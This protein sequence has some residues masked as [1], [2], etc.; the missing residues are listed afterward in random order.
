M[1][2]QTAEAVKLSVAVIKGEIAR[3]DE[4]RRQAVGSLF[5][6]INE[7][8]RLRW[9]YEGSG[10]CAGDDDPDTGDGLARW[11]RDESG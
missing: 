7:L 6:A 8:S 11:Y 2:K 10:E 4:D 3:V 9:S 1:R 5:E